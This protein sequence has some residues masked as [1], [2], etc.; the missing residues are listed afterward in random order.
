MGGMKKVLIHFLGVAAGVGAWA[1]ALAE[2]EAWLL[3][4][5]SDRIAVVAVEAGDEALFC[6]GVL[7]ECGA[8]DIPALV[9]CCADP[10]EVH[11]RAE[12]AA[13]RLSLPADSVDLLEDPQGQL[14]TLLAAFAPS[15]AILTRPGAEWMEILAEAFPD[16]ADR[17]AVLVPSVDA[18]VADWQVTLAPF[19][20]AGKAEALG[21][22]GLSGGGEEEFFDEIEI[23]DFV[24]AGEEA[25]AEEQAPVASSSEVLPP[26]DAPRAE[27]APNALRPRTRLPAVPP[28]PKGK[29]K[30]KQKAPAAPKVYRSWA[31]EPVSW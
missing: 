27:A 26:M 21:I 31:D 14:P 13:R 4:D 12:S 22:Y 5:D 20:Q 18:G 19:E 11:G 3:G 8:L 28:P 30:E 7:Q 9:F 16:P 6:G 17:P 29:A 1:T 10:D 2:P 24:E 25:M 23:D 15:H